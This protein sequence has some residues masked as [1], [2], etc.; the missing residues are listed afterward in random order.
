MRNTWC[1]PVLL[2]MTLGVAACPSKTGRSDI[3]PVAENVDA[4]ITPDNFLQF[5]NTY[6]VAG[7]SRIDIP[8]YAEAYFAAIDPNQ[9]RT[10]LS[11]WKALN[12]FDSG[13][14][15]HVTFR[16]TKDLGYGRDMYART[17]ADGGIAIYVDNYVVLALP[18]DATSYGPINLDA[19]VRK[20]QRYKLGTSTIE[21]SAMDQS[22]PGSDKIVKMISFGPP[23]AD[24]TQRRLGA[25]DLDGRGVKHLPTSCFSCHGGN[26]YPLRS[27]GSF[28]VNTLR[29]AKMNM[30]E[31]STYAFPAATEAAQRAG[32]K[33]INQLVYDHYLDLD[34]R[35]D[36]E[37]A[38]WNN[39][40]AVELVAGPYGGDF[41]G[42]VYDESFVPAGWRQDTGRPA[43][44]ERLYREVV[45]PHCIQCHSLRGN[46]A[47][48]EFGVLVSLNGRDVALGN[49]ISFS[50]YEKF[51]SYNDDIIERVYRRANMPLSLLNYSK[52]WR[53]PA[54]P[55]ALLASFLNGFDV[56]DSSGNISPPGRPVPLV[57]AGRTVTSPVVQDAS[58]SL[59]SESFAW[60]IVSKPVAASATLGNPGRAATTLTADTDGEYVLALAASNAMASAVAQVVLTIDSSLQ[61]TPDELTF[62][63]DVRA[64]LSDASTSESC[65]SCHKPGSDVVGGPV[66]LHDG[67]PTLYE[68]VM[69]RV[70]FNDPENSF[71]LRKPSSLQHG[72]G[73]VLD[74]SDPRENGNYIILLNWIR[75]GAPCGDDPMFCN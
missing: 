37:R 72:G 38:K 58:G 74:R 7:K 22:D 52:F 26:V 27:D 47:G 59:F 53:N 73:L 25:L 16:D 65:V 49:A 67:N 24:G 57:G 1:L 69:E 6:M 28:P 68:D 2:M 32:I 64:V 56:F 33:Q 34:T 3:V 45:Q 4:T 29:S 71:F 13:A 44:V 41:S 5:D 51:I 70:N 17:R 11:A 31:P 42:D 48:E 55:P 19:A 50:S 46:N 63:T 21:Y 35:P 60:S 12:G 39:G 66:R 61:P 10:T 8:A 54:G 40:F 15:V 30:L 20:D 23:A 36:S 62:D 14:D 43:G 9:E 18:G 75:N